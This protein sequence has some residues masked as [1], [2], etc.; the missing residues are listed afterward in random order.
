MEA[1]LNEY[2]EVLSN[3]PGRTSVVEHVFNTADSKPVRQ[4]A[5]CLPHAYRNK[6]RDE[7]DRMLSHDIIEPSSS[8]YAAPIVLFQKGRLPTPLCGLPPPEQCFDRRCVP[9]AENRQHD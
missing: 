5:Y 2:S 6:V 1:L 4:Q 3:Q 8:D 7:L 9:D